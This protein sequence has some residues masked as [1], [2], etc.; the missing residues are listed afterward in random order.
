MLTTFAYQK[1]SML[2]QV[3]AMVRFKVL[4]GCTW[5]KIGR[6]CHNLFCSKLAPVEV[7]GF[8][9]TSTE[10][11]LAY[12]RLKARGSTTELHSHVWGL[13][14]PCQAFCNL[15]LL[16]HTTR[17]QMP[18]FISRCSHHSR[19]GHLD[20]LVRSYDKYIATPE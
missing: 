18:E 14:R 1:Y 11:S 20:Y 3:T 19:A 7:I 6:P 16:P 5:V 4:A 9:P 8:E 2:S 13:S 15:W 12:T 17:L 10:V